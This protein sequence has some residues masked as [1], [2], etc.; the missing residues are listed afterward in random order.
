MALVTNIRPIYHNHWNTT[1]YLEKISESCENESKPNTDRRI[2]INQSHWNET[3][4]LEIFENEKI[5][6]TTMLPSYLTTTAAKGVQEEE[7]DIGDDLM[8]VNQIIIA[9]LSKLYISTNLSRFLNYLYYLYD[10][11]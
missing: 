1:E 11:L 9:I 6:F 2:S 10:G 5:T 7:D 3:A 4:Y 8:V